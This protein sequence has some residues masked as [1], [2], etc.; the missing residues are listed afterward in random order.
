MSFLQREFA[1]AT[2]QSWLLAG[3]QLGVS[4]FQAREQMAA[5]SRAAEMEGARQAT[6]AGRA[7]FGGAMERFQIRTAAGYEESLRR[8][9]FGQAIG[10]QR[11]ASGAAGVIGGRTQQLIEARSQAA[12]TREQAMARYQREMSLEASRFRETT[13]LEDART[14]TQMAFTQA[15]QQRRQATLTFWGDVVNT[16]SS[17]FGG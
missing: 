4:L 15:G 2:G 7:A 9:Q 14:A 5:A 3:A 12:F 10:A 17:L 8:Q 16:A 13:A 6:I 1:G 11:A